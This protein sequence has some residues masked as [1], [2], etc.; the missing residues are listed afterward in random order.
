LAAAGAIRP[1]FSF[2]PKPATTLRVESSEVFVLDRDVWRF[3]LTA[4]AAM[5]VMALAGVARADEKPSYGPPAKWVQVA[6]IPAPPVDDQAPSAQ[7]LLNDNQSQHD[8]VGSAFYNRRIVK[9][10]KPEGLQG[11]SRSVTWD[12]VRDKITLHTLA[13]IRNGQRI[14]LLNQGQDV[15]VLR[16]E[17]NLERAMLDGRMTASI[18]IK[19]LQVGDIVDWSYTQEHREA[20]LGGRTSD[21]EA[22]AWSGVAGRYRVRLLWAD[23]TP[24]TWKVT[25]GFPQPK[26]S[27]TG[28]TNEL[29]VDLLDVKSPKPPIGAPMRFLRPGMLE[30]TTYTGWEDVSRRMAPLYAKASELSADSSLRPEIAQIAAASADPKVR[31]FKALQLVEDKTRYL[32]L[33]MGDGG[34]KPASVDETWSRRFGDCKGKTVLLLTILRELGVEAEPVLVSTNGGDGLEAR[35]PS[36]AL[37]NHVLVRARIGGKSYW[38]DGTRSGDVGAIDDLR[39]PPFRWA[40]P[41]RAGGGAIE[42]IVQGPLDRPDTEGVIRIDASG[43]LDK[44]APTVMTTTLRGEGG[45]GLA[46]A[47]RMT[48]RADLERSLK[49]Q[50]SSS[51][52]WLT[53]E[54][55]DFEVTPQGVARI[56]ISGVADMEWRLNDDVGAREYKLPGSGSGVVKAFPR[57]EPGP[58]ADAPYATAFPA[59]SS[60]VVE[61][62]LPN[63]GGGFSVKGPNWS[64]RVANVEVSRTAELRDGVARFTQSSRSVGRELPFAEVEEANK[65][66]RRLAGEVQIVRAPKGL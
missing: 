39:P 23:G 52:S 56:V 62:V 57:R 40:L 7:L 42:E 4:V 29:L 47:L 58:N 43:G 8:T 13:I 38:L 10:L 18:Q 54:K 24:L 51:N 61:V 53:I 50:F 65:A 16:R 30:A 5:S 55:I 25:T 64:G 36:A 12:P 35:L 37:F 19:D 20:L 3:P 15:L 45:L 22:M 28:K 63:Q 31:A 14:D 27:K 33:G 48:P 11:G 6:D 17:K 2:A 9:V 41:V 44:P 49:Q 1:P 46:R 21:F 66:A 59:Y 34:Y 26:V 32:F 60:A